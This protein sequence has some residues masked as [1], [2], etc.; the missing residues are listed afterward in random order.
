M[1]N[2]EKPV[3]VSA[4]G[5]RKLQAELEELRTA[6]RTEVAERI[7]AAME[8]G[9]FTENSELEQAK[10]DQAF[11][12]G[13][14]MTLEQMIKN[15]QIID[16]NEKHDLVEVGSHVTV[17]ADGRKEKYTIVGSAEASP[18]R[19][20][21][22]QRVAGRTRAPGSPR[23]RDGQ[24]SVPRAHG[25]E[26]PGGQL[27]VES[28]ASVT[29]K[30]SEQGHQARFWADEEADLLATDRQHVI[31]DS[32]TPS[33]AVPISGLRGPIIT[34]AL[35]RTFKK[36]GLQIRY[37]FTIDDYDPMDSQSLKEKAAWVE[38][39]GKPFAHIPSPEPSVASDFA[40]YHASAYLETFATLGIRPEEIHW[41]R[42]LYG[43]GELDTQIDLV[44]RNA[45]AIREIYERVSHVTKDER[46]L[47]IGVICENCGRLGTTFA[48]DYD[49]KTVAYECRRTSSN[50]P[51]AADTRTPLAIQGQRQALLEPAVVRD[52]GPLRVT[53]EEGGKDLFT[54]ADHAIART[55]SIARSGR[56]IRPS[57]SCTS[58][59][60]S[61]G[62]KMSTSKPGVEGARRRGTIRQGLPARAR[63]LPMLRTHPKRHIDFDPTG[64]DLLEAVRRVRP[65]RA[66][67]I[68]PRRTAT[69]QR[70]WS[71][72][73]IDEDH[74][75]PVFAC[76]SASLRTG[77]RSPASEPFGEAEERK[78]RSP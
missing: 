26:D 22:Q 25:N 20:Q 18:A 55:R 47:P 65:L 32:K 62:K 23:G 45:A 75:P 35:Y 70:S 58:S 53:Y 12:E 8:F 39:M 71:L 37:V 51:R 46:W 33:G 72:S 17:E 78:G 31:R 50:G 64:N 24:V 14:I 66:T 10:N 21:D 54:A 73:Q 28:T 49:G 30:G 15:A 56:R 68:S 69:R 11:L 38:H 40:R 3:Y 42:D 13:R 52:V 27:S 48:F 61:G 6:K 9:D 4:D 57:V 77:C 67:R 41:M 1:N 34:D 43:K 36:H 44:L 74:A 76:A 19:G 60:T 5:L 2:L 29:T 16:E 63:A 7:H 59:C